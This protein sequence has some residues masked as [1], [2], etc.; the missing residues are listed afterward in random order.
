MARKQ[1][2]ETVAPRSTSQ[3]TI[4][5]IAAHM[6]VSRAT[7]THVL[8]G[9]ATEQRIRPDT[10]RRVLEAA[11]ALG[12]RAN[13]SARAIR[14]GRFGN[15]ALV[16]SELG[17]YLPREL[18]NGLTK[19][20]ADKDMHLVLIEVPDRVI[21]DESY[22]PHTMR[23]LSADG[24]LINRHIGFSQPFLDR[25][26]RL[27]IPAIS[28][29]VRQEF[30]CVHP[31]DQMGGRI[32]AEFL[33][34]LGHERI[35]YVDTEGPENRHYSKDDRRAGYEQVMTAAGKTPRVY[36]LPK[37]WRMS[38][39]PNRDGRVESARLLLTQGDR[40]T[41]VIAYELAEAM[42]IVHAAHLRGL[43]IPEDLSIIL[44]HNRRD[45]R[46]FLPFHTVSNVMAE[47]GAEAVRMLLEKIENPEV[48]LAARVI[49]AVI[50]GGA[51][52]MS[53]TR[54]NSPHS[55]G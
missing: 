48:A 3:P 53:P 41:A 43:R 37:Q 31:D 30:D 5:T 52:C 28:L 38:E 14:A 24:L 13:T 33:L 8:N 19:A 21:D 49:P 7:V 17:L 25:I 22:L 47:V 26:Q 27:R 54:K 42:A 15:I 34:G 18:L 23:E 39:Q 55:V 2:S 11:R 16:Q 32:A 50:I 10:Q 46:Y 12:Y 4:A 6:G 35:A 29:N 45:D 40:P 44:F 9:R 51:T 1:I 20:I 36:W